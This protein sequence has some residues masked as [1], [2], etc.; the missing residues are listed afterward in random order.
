MDPIIILIIAILIVSVVIHEVA[1]GVAANYLGDPT[2][3][4]AGRLTLNPIKH[5][6]PVGSLLVP[7]VLAILPTGFIFGWAKPVPFNPYNLK[8][9]RWGP[10]IVAVAGPLSNILIA[11]IFGLALRFGIGAQFLS[12][13]ALVAVFYIIFINLV[14]AVFNMMPVPPLDGS[15]VLFAALPYRFQYIEQVMTRYF[16]LFIIFI[17]YFFGTIIVPL[18]FFLFNLITGIPPSLLFG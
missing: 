2:A 16:L 4:L 1:H 10:A 8:A 15:K 9:G 14:L 18:V 17:I 5:I 7:A 13:A 6:D 11:V 12:P 3:K